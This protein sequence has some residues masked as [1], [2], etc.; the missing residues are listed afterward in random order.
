MTAS[1]DHQS[2]IDEI[3]ERFGIKPECV[4]EIEK[5]SIDKL[6]TRTITPDQ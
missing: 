3:G 4:A 5:R 6:R 2:T 1:G